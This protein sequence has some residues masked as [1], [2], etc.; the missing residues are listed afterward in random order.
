MSNAEAI[1]LATKQVK[2]IVQLWS[3]ICDE[4][5]LNKVDRNFLWRRQFLN[6]YA[7][8]EAPEALTRLIH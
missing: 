3:A 7:F 6:P 2:T 1:L 8:L 4:A 5:K